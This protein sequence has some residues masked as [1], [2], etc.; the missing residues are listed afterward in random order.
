MDSNGR[1]PLARAAEE[2]YEAVAR[3]LLE[4]GANVESKDSN[5]RT[6]LARAAWQGHEAVVRLLLERGA[7]VETMDSNGRTPLSRAA[8]Q[9]REAEAKDSVSPR[10]ISI[11]R[12]RYRVPPSK[13]KD[14]SE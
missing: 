10:R 11:A 7:N 14:L 4:K 5:G 8:P 2:G 1:T 6:P 9:G 3:L 12:H 13:G